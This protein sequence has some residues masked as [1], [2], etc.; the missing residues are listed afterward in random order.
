MADLESFPSIYKDT[1]S[2]STF[3]PVTPSDKSVA[4]QPSSIFTPRVVS[5]PTLSDSDS[6]SKILDADSRLLPLEYNFN[7]FQDGIKDMKCQAKN[8]AQRNAK[9][10]ADI[11]ALLHT[12]RQ[13]GTCL[14][15][16][17]LPGPSDK[18]AN[19]PNQISNASSFTGAASSGSQPSKEQFCSPGGRH[20]KSIPGYL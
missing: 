12:K 11:L 16:S 19:H 4:M 2:V 7:K 9:K 8:E 5:Q 1:D 14:A 6:V 10:L 17:E 13:G 15:K 18:L 3:N 20:S